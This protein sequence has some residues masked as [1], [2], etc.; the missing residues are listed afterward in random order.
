[1]SSIKKIFLNFLLIFSFFIVG[2]T[3]LAWGGEISLPTGF[4]QSEFKSFSE[5]IGMAVSYIPAAPAEPLGIIGFD[6][7]LEV[8]TVPISDNAPFWTKVTSGPPGM[9]AL[10]KIHVQKGLPLGI[11][12]G[13]VYSS[14]PQVKISMLGGELK[15][16]ILSGG[17][18]MPAVA[19]RGAYT[20]LSG[21]DTLDLNT[22]STDLSISKGFAMVTPYV[23]VGQVQITSKGKGIV[24]LL[25]E[26]KQRVNKSFVGAKISFALINLVAEVD[27]AKDPIYTL[28]LNLGL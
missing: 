18:A 28:R 19:I 8:T 3:G 16:A 21:I 15:Y 24:A 1:M 26:E 2:Q 17:V 9:L 22:L 10:P 4:A 11:D 20:K 7:G 14:I 6:V 27:F 12:V 25:K 13:V 5:E 23:G